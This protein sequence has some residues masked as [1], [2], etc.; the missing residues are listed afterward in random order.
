MTTLTATYCAFCD[1]LRSFGSS[2]VKSFEIAGYARAAAEL[3]RQGYTEH[4]DRVLET[5]RQVR[6]ES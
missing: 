6:K 5:L 1:S 2:V 4:A 3:R